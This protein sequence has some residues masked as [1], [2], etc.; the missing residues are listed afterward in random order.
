MRRPCPV[1]AG[2]RQYVAVVD[3]RPGAD[4]LALGPEDIEQQLCL[5]GPVWVVYA[6]DLRSPEFKLRKFPLGEPL[7]PGTESRPVAA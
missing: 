5:P 2:R 3:M 7:T 4:M 6:Q 1:F